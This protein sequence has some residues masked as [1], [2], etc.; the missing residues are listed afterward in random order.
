MSFLRVVLQG[1]IRGEALRGEGL[2]GDALRG[3]AL[4][5]E[6]TSWRTTR[7]T[8]GRNTAR[9]GLVEVTKRWQPML[10]VKANA[11]EPQQHSHQGRSHS[12]PETWQTIS[13]ANGVENQLGK[14]QNISQCDL[15]FQHSLKRQPSLF[16]ACWWRFSMLGRR[17]PKKE[18]H[19]TVTPPQINISPWKG[20]IFNM[21]I[22]S[23]NRQFSGDSVDGRNPKPTPVI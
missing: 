11:G 19:V 7:W 8:T 2:R 17:T 1:D 9:R 23:S 13:T 20:A 10:L 5:G 3:E 12:I 6:G 18:T 22:Q 14:K 16:P 4:R 21:K 15:I